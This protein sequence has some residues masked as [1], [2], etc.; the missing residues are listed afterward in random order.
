M[1]TVLDNYAIIWDDPAAV[2]LMGLRAYVGNIPC[3]I[4]DYNDQPFA[5]AYEE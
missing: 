1:C 2:T 4:L 5:G 3:F